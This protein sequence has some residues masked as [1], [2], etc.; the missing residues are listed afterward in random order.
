MGSVAVVT[1]SGGPFCGKHDFARCSG[2]PTPAG[3]TAVPIAPGCYLILNSCLCS[4][5]SHSRFEIP[6]HDRTIEIPKSQAQNKPQEP[7]IKPKKKR[8]PAFAQCDPAGP[9]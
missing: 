3:V 6:N 1:K 7:N 4:C 2:I 9:G 5:S 8:S